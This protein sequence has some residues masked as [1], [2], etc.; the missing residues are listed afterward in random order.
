MSQRTTESKV[1]ISL[2]QRLSVEEAI[3]ELERAY[4]I[5]SQDNDGQQMLEFVDADKSWVFVGANVKRLAKSAQDRLK[6][7]IGQKANEQ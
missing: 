6:R 4:R 5:Y 7:W 1:S 2:P 3:A